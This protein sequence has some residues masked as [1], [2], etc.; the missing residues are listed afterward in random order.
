MLDN[1]T[2]S[3]RDRLVRWIPE[4]FSPSKVEV[5]RR[6]ADSA[7]QATVEGLGTCGAQRHSTIVGP[8]P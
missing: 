7:A 4:K 3:N 5:T 2:G 1:F 6:A 8:T